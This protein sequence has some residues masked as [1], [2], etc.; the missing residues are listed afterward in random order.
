[1]IAIEQGWYSPSLE[2]AFQI[3]R[4]FDVPLEDVFP[5]PR[6]RARTAS[7]HPEE[8]TMMTTPT[9]DSGRETAMSTSHPDLVDDV[10]IGVRLKISALWAA[11]LFLFA[12]GD[13]FGFFNPGQ[14]E[15][16]IG[17]E[18]AGMQITQWFL[19]GVSIHVAMASVMI[20][21]TL[22]LRPTAS[23]WANIVLPLLYVISIVASVFG[24]QPYFLFLSAAEIMLLLLIVR[25]A[26]TWPRATR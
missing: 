2:V 16:V 11:M 6:S 20:F 23:R 21:L 26:W 5:V 15:E 22:V 4:V 18:I 17:G 9:D 8:V 25:Y 3:A 24:E 14:I 12:Y 1:M 7:A 13:I 19:F 10:P